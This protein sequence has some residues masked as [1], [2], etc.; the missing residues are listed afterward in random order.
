MSQAGC[1]LGM[2]RHVDVAAADVRT[3]LHS[4][5]LPCLPM[6]PLP[7][8]AAPTHYGQVPE[9]AREVVLDTRSDEFYR[10]HAG[11]NFGEV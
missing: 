2:P 10:K 6:Q 8:A 9:D 1:M 11:L 5:A 3:A 7:R 4:A